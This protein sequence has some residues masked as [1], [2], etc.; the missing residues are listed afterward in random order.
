MDSLIEN[1]L[2]C[3]LHGN[4]NRPRNA[5]CCYCWQ[6]S[7]F[8]LIFLGKSS[9]DFFHQRRSRKNLTFL[10]S[11]GS[12]TINALFPFESWCTTNARIVCDMESSRFWT[13]FFSNETDF[14]SSFKISIENF[15][16][17][18][19]SSVKTHWCFFVQ[20]NPY[21]SEVRK[22]ALFPDI[23]GYLNSYFFSALLA[24]FFYQKVYR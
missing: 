17:F 5:N 14:I 9:L 4:H 13:S 20:W 3:C 15:P 24:L 11:V 21:G 18:S 1:W 19:E 8:S 16:L 23:T 22:N 6:I 10:R 12:K 7:M 2:V